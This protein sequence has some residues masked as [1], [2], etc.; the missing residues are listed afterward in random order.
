MDY[1]DFMDY[2]GIPLLLP[3]LAQSLPVSTLAIYIHLLVNRPVIF[4]L[5]FVGLQVSIGPFATDMLSTTDL[6]IV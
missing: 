3:K 5:D 1:Y 2:I 6:N 4:A